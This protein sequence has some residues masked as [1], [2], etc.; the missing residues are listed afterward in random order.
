[1][2]HSLLTDSIITKVVELFKAVSE[3]ALLHLFVHV[4]YQVLE[5]HLNIL[6]IQSA[7]F[8][9][10]HLYITEEEGQDWMG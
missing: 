6:R 3:L 9:E 8:Q 5:G 10:A 2:L 1:M 4:C 7:R